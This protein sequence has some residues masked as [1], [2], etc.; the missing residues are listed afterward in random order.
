MKYRSGASFLSFRIKALKFKLKS[1]FIKPRIDVVG[2]LGAEDV[3]RAVTE[4]RAPAEC[5]A[6]C[7]AGHQ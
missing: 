5:M 7:H 4:I 2:K 6:N 1:P 3:S